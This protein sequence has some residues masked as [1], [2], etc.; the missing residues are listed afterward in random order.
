MTVGDVLYCSEGGCASCPVCRGTVR[1]GTSSDCLL[2]ASVYVLCLQRAIAQRAWL[3][4]SL[5]TPSHHH[6]PLLPAHLQGQCKCP[7]CCGTGKRASW[8][9]NGPK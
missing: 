8:L 2:A 7:N 1:H 9:A 6:H 3:H 4:I 5:Q